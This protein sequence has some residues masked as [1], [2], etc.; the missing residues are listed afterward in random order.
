MSP[1]VVPTDLFDRLTEAYRSYEPPSVRNLISQQL[2]HVTARA[3]ARAAKAEA[4]FMTKVKQTA[5]MET[6][7]GQAQH[8]NSNARLSQN[9]QLVI[10]ALLVI[11]FI[12]LIGVIISNTPTLQDQR[13]HYVT[14]A[15]QFMVRGLEFVYAFFE[16]L[17]EMVTRQFQN[18]GLHHV[19]D[20]MIEKYGELKASIIKKYN[21]LVA[22]AAAQMAEE[23][24]MVVKKQG[25]MVPQQPRSVPAIIG[26][27]NVAVKE[28]IVD[29]S[30]AGQDMDVDSDT[31]KDSEPEALDETD[32]LAVHVDAADYN[33]SESEDDDDNEED[34]LDG[35]DYKD[36][37][38]D[39][40]E[41]EAEEA[42]DFA[43]GVQ[44][45]DMCD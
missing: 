40:S 14:P 1:R 34:V 15:V 23:E 20:T 38:E 44:D 41:A 30:I 39:D 6:L 35:Q 17:G 18:D 12:A 42:E 2:A 22:W 11:N 10:A 43:E 25:G 33:L 24:K 45:W 5:F 8:A 29:P 13:D 31:E 19:L 26:Q 3:A 36:A 21:E 7:V 4:E 16:K 28:E 32:S 37:A 27:R 9:V